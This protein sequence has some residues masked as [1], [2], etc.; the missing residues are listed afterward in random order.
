MENGN[1]WMERVDGEGDRLRFCLR[2]PT[3]NFNDRNE[4]LIF[5]LQFF[6]VFVVVDLLIY[7]IIC[8]V[9]FQTSFNLK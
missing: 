2:A 7:S 5:A 9:A 6:V 4:Y 1:G 3:R 8:Q